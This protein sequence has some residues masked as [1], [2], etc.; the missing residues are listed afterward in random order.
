MAVYTDLRNLSTELDDVVRTDIEF[1]NTKDILFEYIDQLKIEETFKNKI[2]DKAD[3]IH[4]KVKKEE[5][6]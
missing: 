6:K 3:I 2:K 5:I 1:K 4:K